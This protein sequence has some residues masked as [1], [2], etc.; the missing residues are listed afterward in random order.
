[1][2][3]HSSHT[4]CRFDKLLAKVDRNGGKVLEEDPA[5]VKK[6]DA[7]LVVMRPIKPLCCEALADYP[8]LGRFVVRDIRQIVAAGDIKSVQKKEIPK[9]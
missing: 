4:A 5:F 3:C 9:V 1:L 7:A 8:P 6:G 2:D